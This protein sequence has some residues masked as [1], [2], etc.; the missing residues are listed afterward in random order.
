MSASNVFTVLLALIGL[1]S[2]IMTIH[3]FVELHQHPKIKQSPITVSMIVVGVIF[4]LSLILAPVMFF[5][6]MAS[7]SQHLPRTGKSTGLS[8]SFAVYPN[9]NPSGYVGDIGDIKSVAK[10]PG[11]LVRFTYEA[12]GRGPHE[13]EYK[14]L[15]DGSL[16]P[17]P[18]KFAG[19]LYLDPPNNFGTDPRGG[20]DLR[21][22]HMLT[23]KARSLNGSVY[24]EFVIGGVTWMWDEKTHTRVEVPYPESL[25]RTSL[26]IIKL[27]ET[28]QTFHYDLSALSQDEL[29]D[30][31]AGFGW[32][33]TWDSNGVQFTGSGQP[34]TFTIEIQD[35]AYER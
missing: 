16:N 18:C 12:K 28:W 34:T 11:G 13:W 25:P 32:V 14:Y 1:V 17:A 23:W 4:V 9:Y 3:S 5:L 27:T 19:V 26:G 8:A 22:R 10:E 7:A 29:R 24:V 21:G 33:I 30:V 31:V 2:G 35:I 20:F 6:G 15:D